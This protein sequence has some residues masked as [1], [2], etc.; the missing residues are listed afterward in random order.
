MKTYLAELNDGGKSASF[1]TM[2][3]ALEYIAKNYQTDADE[4]GTW[5]NDDIETLVWMTQDAADAAEDNSD[6]IAAITITMKKEMTVSELARLAGS[7]K[8]EAKSNAARANGKKGGRHPKPATAMLIRNPE[9]GW[10]LCS[11]K[12]DI[13]PSKNFDTQAQ[14]RDY[15]ASKNWGVKRLP[16]CDG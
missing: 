6:V 8:S 12:G 5:S 9:G 15:A 14:A 7:A 11:W 13:I 4:L 3:E 10:T 16:E 2:A 1:A